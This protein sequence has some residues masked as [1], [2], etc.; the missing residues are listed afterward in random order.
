M[1]AMTT[2][3]DWKAR[4]AG[5]FGRWLLDE[6][7]YFNPDPKAGKI[8]RYYRGGDGRADKGVYIEV[9][10]DG[11]AEVGC[12]HGAV[13]RFSSAELT[14]VYSNKAGDD[15]ATAAQVVIGRFNEWLPEQIPAQLPLLPGTQLHPTKR[16]RKGDR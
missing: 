5:G 11:V 1:S 6:E 2:W 10:A 4:A 8:L 16:K 12:Y 9:R 14:A 3:E 15:L 13:P 7:T